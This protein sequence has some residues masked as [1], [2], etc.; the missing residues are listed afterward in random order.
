MYEVTY[1]RTTSLTVPK[2]TNEQTDSFEQLKI[3]K[4]HFFC[5]LSFCL[6]VQDFVHLF[7]T[8]VHIHEEKGR[9]LYLGWKGVSA[10]QR[11]QVFQGL[12]Q[13]WK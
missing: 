9:L 3:G 11:F 2:Q 7:T 4:F 5:I 6:S 1:T 10:P 12:V 13:K 8:Y